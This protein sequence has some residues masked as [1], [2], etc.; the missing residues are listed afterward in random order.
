MLYSLVRLEPGL[1][2]LLSILVFQFVVALPTGFGGDDVFDDATSNALGSR[3]SNFYAR[4]LPLG[5]S[6]VQG[7]GSS[8]GNG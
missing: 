3:A 6:I 8:S 2:F 7:Q 4:I 1:A 5:A